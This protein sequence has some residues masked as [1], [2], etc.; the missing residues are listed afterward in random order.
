MAP[1]PLEGG[2]ILI[3]YNNGAPNDKTTID[4][5]QINDFSVLE[6]EALENNGDK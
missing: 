1:S 6:L 2:N 3:G 4:H 5:N